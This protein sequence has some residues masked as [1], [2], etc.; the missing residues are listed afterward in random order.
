MKAF[1]KW[2][3]C[4]VS[5]ALIALAFYLWQWKGMNAAGNILLFLVWITFGLRMLMGFLCDK[6]A[7]EDQYKSVALTRYNILTDFVISCAF[8]AFGY[9]GAAACNMIGVLFSMVAKVREPTPK[10]AND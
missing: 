4:I 3:S 10:E 5:D 1:K 7:F 6:T 9:F 2:M 8:A